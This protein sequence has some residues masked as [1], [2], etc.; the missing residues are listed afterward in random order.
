MNKC[1]E[2]NDLI[3]AATEFF[4]MAMNVKEC[5]NIRKNR[6]KSKEL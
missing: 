3:S 4:I 2:K 6:N 1:N 5:L